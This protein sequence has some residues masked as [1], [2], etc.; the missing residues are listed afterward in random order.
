[1]PHSA[2]R[3]IACASA[4]VL[5]LS[6][7]PPATAAD[8]AVTIGEVI[9]TAQKKAENINDVPLSVTAVQGDK[10]DAIRS[11]GGDIRMLSARVPSLT[12]ESSFGR[13]FPRPYIRGLGKRPTAFEIV[14]RSAPG[15]CD[16]LRTHGRAIKVPNGSCR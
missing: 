1:M 2:L 8:E 12:L 11:G 5:A 6:F 13:T 15:A 10:L 9:V 14:R 3:A 7:A 16:S 4:S